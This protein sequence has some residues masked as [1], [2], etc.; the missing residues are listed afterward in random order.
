MDDN[1]KKVYQAFI[2]AGFSDKQ[3]KALTAEVGR[4]NAYQSKYIFGHHTDMANSADNLGFFSWQGDRKKNLL[5]KLQERGL[6]S[7]GRIK[8]GQEALNT[9]AEFAKEE[10]ENISAYKKTKEGFL[11]NPNVS[12]KEA[13]ELL[14]R[15]YLRWDMDGKYIKNVAEH[16]KRR[17]NFYNQISGQPVVEVSQELKE[18][19]PDNFTIEGNSGS[20]LTAGE[21][22]EPK[23][24]QEAKQELVQAQNEE[25][26]LNDLSKLFSTQQQ[27]TEEQYQPNYL[28]QSELFQIQPVQGIQYQEQQPF[29]YAQDGGIIKDDNGYWNPNNWGKTVEI[30]SPYITM[31]GVNQPLIGISKQTGEQK[32]MQPGKKYFFKDTNQV[33]EKPIKNA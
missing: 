9:M 28:Q 15:N 19:Q 22:K 27:V 10:M 23:E 29:M 13:A 3:A 17:D 14:G 31:E 6:Y 24:V 2:N 18:G 30:N 16:K 25:N 32:I 12:Q 33:I 5:K 21:Y 8:E 7:N 11:S 26:F 20:L 1:I 4:E